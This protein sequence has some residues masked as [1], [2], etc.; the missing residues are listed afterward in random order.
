MEEESSVT[1][2]RSNITLLKDVCGIKVQYDSFLKEQIIS[3]RKLISLIKEKREEKSRLVFEIKKY[4]KG[5]EELTKL[6]HKK[7]VICE[8]IDKIQYQI[9]H[10]DDS[11]KSYRLEQMHSYKEK[12]KYISQAKSKLCKIV[13][14][15]MQEE[16]EKYQKAVKTR[17]EEI[18]PGSKTQKSLEFYDREFI[19]MIKTIC[20]HEKY[21]GESKTYGWICIHCEE[22]CE[23]LMS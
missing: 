4:V 22:R 3:K 13:D 21:K 7:K 23:L 12:H 1:E 16:L 14:G 8:E 19:E 5:S 9:D 10:F 2:T 11:L 18:D 6:F 17:I 20:P 15:V